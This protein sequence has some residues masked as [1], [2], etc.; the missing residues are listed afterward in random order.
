M[1]IVG[2]IVQHLEHGDKKMREKIKKIIDKIKND[3]VMEIPDFYLNIAGRKFYLSLEQMMGAPS[4]IGEW[5]Y[6]DATTWFMAVRID[7]FKNSPIWFRTTATISGQMLE[8]MPYDHIEN[9]L[10]MHL[11]GALTND[12]K[13]EVEE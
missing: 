8:D 3:G 9:I 2:L 6:C 4:Y 5:S 13:M 1:V 12:L 10:M 7:E 11:Q